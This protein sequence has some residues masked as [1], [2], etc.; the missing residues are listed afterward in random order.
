MNRTVY[1]VNATKTS[2]LR[3]RWGESQNPLWKKW[4]LGVSRYVPADGDWSE[5]QFVG[6]ETDED[7]ALALARYNRPHVNGWQLIENEP[8]A[9]INAMKKA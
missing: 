9:L 7:I 2:L 6:Y 4:I 5:E 3:L 8:T 1:A